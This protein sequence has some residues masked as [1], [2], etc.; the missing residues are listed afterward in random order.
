MFKK[1][2]VSTLFL[3]IVATGSILYYC[4]YVLPKDVKNYQDYLEKNLKKDSQKQACSPTE[5][6]R[7]GVQKDIWRLNENTRV[8][9]QI[10]AETSTL[11]LT[12]SGNTLFMKETMDNILCLIQE[13][14]YQ[15]SALHPMQQLKSFHADHGL[16]DYSSHHFAAETVFLDFYTLPEHDLP[17]TL[18][19][20]S[21]FL[22]GLAKAVSFTL[23]EKG[24]SFHAEKF[25]A[26]MHSFENNL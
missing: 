24:P 4:F 15:D 20:D 18:N 16:Y 5:Q 7:Y 8:H 11:S 17:I 25:K 19:P 1:A 9:Y 10:Q 22:K 13:K 21:A 2:F 3:L 26:Q 23:S 12:P 14:L 6:L